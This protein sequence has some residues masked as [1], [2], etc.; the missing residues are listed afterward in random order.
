MCL[1][2]TQVTMQESNPRTFNSS[3]ALKA[4][5]ENIMKLSDHLEQI[6]LMFWAG[7]FDNQLLYRVLQ[8]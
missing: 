8:I 3:Q 5:V 1:L 7:Q 6:E 2:F 4:P